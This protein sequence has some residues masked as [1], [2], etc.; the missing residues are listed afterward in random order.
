[1]ANKSSAV[2][3]FDSKPNVPTLGDAVNIFVRSVVCIAVYFAAFI[4]NSIYR[5]VQQLEPSPALGAQIGLVLAIICWF[6]L[7]RRR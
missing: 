3:D 6:A 7:P 5:D 1:M 2:L 4:G